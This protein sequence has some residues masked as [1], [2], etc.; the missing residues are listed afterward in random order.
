MGAGVT[1]ADKRRDG[2]VRRAEQARDGGT[3]LRPTAWRFEL[4]GIVTVEHLLGVVVALVAYQ[5]TDDGHLVH[6]PGKLGKASQILIPV[7]FVA[8]GFQGPA[9]SLGASGFRSNIS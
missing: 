4:F 1:E 5:R 7:T 3:E 6:Q 8:I 9:I 2:R